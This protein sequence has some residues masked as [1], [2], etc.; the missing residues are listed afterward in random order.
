MKGRNTRCIT[1]RLPEVVLYAL[2][3]KSKAKGFSR[4][5]AYIKNQLYKA[6]GY[7]EI[8]MEMPQE[9]ENHEAKSENHSDITTVISLYDPLKHMPGDTVRMVQHGVEKGVIL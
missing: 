6:V 5:G 2:E 1:I 9:Q 7:S 3:G 8:T 4:A